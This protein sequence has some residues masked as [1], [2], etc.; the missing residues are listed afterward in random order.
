MT[1]ETDTAGNQLQEASDVKVRGVIVG[2]VREVERQRRRR[3]HRAGHRP[4]LPRPDPGRRHRPAAAQDPLRRAVRRPARC[5]TARVS[6]PLADGDV[7]GQD[8]SENA[9]E[10]QKVIDDTAAAAAGGP[11]AGPL[12]HPR[13]GRRRA[14][15]PRR[16]ARARTSPRTGEYFGQINTVLPQLQ[17]D[18]SELADFADT[19][20]ARRRRP[21]RRP[22]QPSV[23]NTTVVDQQE[24]L[25]RTFTVVDD[26]RRT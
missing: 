15:R 13:R 17:A 16:R 18:I 23:T 3:H 26:A 6:E 20:D 8:R 25:R 21:A 22:G 7:I 11:A 1:L 12:L 2:D 10:L 19:Y 24:Q 9:I 4:R 5:P 14:A